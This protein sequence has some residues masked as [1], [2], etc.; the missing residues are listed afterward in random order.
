MGED[1]WLPAGSSALRDMQDP[2]RLGQ[3][4]YYHGTY[5]YFGPNDNG[6]VHTNSG[7]ANFAYYLLAMGG[8]GTNDGLSY[9]IIGIGEPAAAAVALRAN[10]H[11]H[12]P[13]AQYADARTACGVDEP[14][15]C[16]ITYNQDD[17]V[18]YSFED[19][20]ATSTALNLNL[21]DHAYISIPFA[22]T[23][24]CGNYT[25]LA[26]KDNGIINFE[27]YDITF[28]NGCIP[29]SQPAFIAPFWDD[30]DPDAA[31]A[32]VYYEVKGTAPS[33]RLIV[34]WDNLRHFDVQGTNG[35]TLQAILFTRSGMGLTPGTLE[36]AGCAGDPL[37]QTYSLFNS[38]GSEKTFSLSYDVATSNAAFFGPTSL[39]VAD[40]ATR[41]FE[42]TLSPYDTTSL[43]EVV[44]GTITAVSGS[45][46]LSARMTVTVGDTWVSIAEEPDN[47]RMDNVVAAYSGKLWSITGYGDNADVR[48]YNPETET[49]TVVA[50]SAPSFGIN[51]ARSGCQAGNTVY[52]Y[53]DTATS[54]FTGLWSYNMDSNT[55]TSLSPGGTGPATTGIWAPAWVYDP[56]DNLCYLT[57]GATT[58]G[59]GDLATV[60]VYDPAADS[61]Q[62]ALPDFTTPRDFHAAWIVGKNTGKKLYIAGGADTITGELD[63][64]Q[65]YGFAGSIWNSENGDLGVLPGTWWG[66]GYAETVVAC[67]SNELLWLTAGQRDDGSATAV[68]AHYNVKEGA[69]FNSGSLATDAVYRTGAVSLDGE[70]YELGGD[71]GGFTYTGQADRF[72]SCPCKFPWPMFL[73]A[74]IGGAE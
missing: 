61:W 55:W 70:L 14:V 67:G 24:Y 38:L 42:V 41:T 47:G 22:F 56:D 30:L 49:W 63:S 33:R 17:T 53:G 36:V 68:T 21:D 20:R 26:I 44:K 28:I 60:H 54:G 73:P 43:G 1:C 45:E 6:G 59:A 58:P 51:Y 35:V 37:K 74:M 10:Y 71:K 23:F 69:W 31:D 72:M 18:T 4:S 64:T 16:A 57:G 39:T 34:Q 40:G 29:A 25:N 19:I 65:C 52:V 13:G 66:M 7:V 27:N 46:K 62:T 50:G 12:T 11:Y 5:W 2:Q 8:S 15:V 32:E 3:P 48:N 9:N